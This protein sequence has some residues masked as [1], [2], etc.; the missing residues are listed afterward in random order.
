MGS[1]TVT[2]VKAVAK[3]TSVGG[4]EKWDLSVDLISIL[5]DYE[6]T[7]HFF[8]GA[9]ALAISATTMAHLLWGEK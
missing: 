7:D 9:L 3:G 8:M 6:R 4:E 2:R 1:E 5:K